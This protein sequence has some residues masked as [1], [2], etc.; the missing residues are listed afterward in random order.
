MASVPAHAALDG[1]KSALAYMTPE[2]MTVMLQGRYRGTPGAAIPVVLTSPVSNALL[3][4]YTSTAILFRCSSYRMSRPCTRLSEQQRPL[5]G[6]ACL[7][8]VPLRH[9]L[10]A[11]AH[12]YITVLRTPHTLQ[13]PVHH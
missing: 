7:D 5:D 11:T 4:S 13:T 2:C 3:A 8:T 1:R 9:A 6:L 10:L 12:S